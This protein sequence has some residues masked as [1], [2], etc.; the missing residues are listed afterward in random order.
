MNANMTYSPKATPLMRQVA[1]ALMR[2]GSVQVRGLLGEHRAV[3]KDDAGKPVVDKDGNE[4]TYVVKRTKDRAVLRLF[5][6]RETQRPVSLLH[7]GET[8][9]YSLS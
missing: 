3:V 7:L 6:E 9:I 4:V 2:N 8:A 1:E 5:L